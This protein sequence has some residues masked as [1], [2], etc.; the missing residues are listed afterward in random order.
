MKALTFFFKLF[1]NFCP[2]P[3]RPLNDQNQSPIQS[4]IIFFIDIGREMVALLF[5][6]FCLHVQFSSYYST[7]LVKVLRALRFFGPLEAKIEESV[8]H[9]FVLI[10]LLEDDAICVAIQTHIAQK[11][12][13]QS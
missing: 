12:K 5:Y 3:L 10:S 2:P 13:F 9:Q 11:E 4:L 8:F 6:L 7:K 1:L